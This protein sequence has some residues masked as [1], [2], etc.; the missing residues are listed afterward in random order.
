MGWLTWSVVAYLLGAD[1]TD[2]SCHR[3]STRIRATF[4]RCWFSPAAS[5]I[6]N[7]LRVAYDAADR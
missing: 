6:G 4:R 1:L 3:R 7:H 2:R 5:M